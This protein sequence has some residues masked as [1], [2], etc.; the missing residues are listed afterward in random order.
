MCGLSTII[1]LAYLFLAGLESL[2]LSSEDAKLFIWLFLADLT[3]ELV[4]LSL[5]SLFK[6]ELGFE[7]VLRS[8]SCLF[9]VRFCSSSLSSDNMT[10]FLCFFDTE[11]ENDPILSSLSSL[12]FGLFASISDHSNKI[13]INFKHLP[14]LFDEMTLSIF[15][16]FE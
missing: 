6:P 2:S 13:S 4:S 7:L 14:F 12:I 10:L 8:L 11:L 9:M 1:H 3:F 15:L 16:V 5:S